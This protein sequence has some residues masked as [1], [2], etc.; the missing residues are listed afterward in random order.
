MIPI[1]DT[2]YLW[3]VNIGENDL[4]RPMAS[5]NGCIAEV[6]QSMRENGLIMFS[7]IP[8]VGTVSSPESLL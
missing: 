3:L 5:S 7:A 8:F 6:S 1:P 4:H 2:Y